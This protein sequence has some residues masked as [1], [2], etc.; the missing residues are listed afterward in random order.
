MLDEGAG[1]LHNNS[2]LR[3]GKSTERRLAQFRDVLNGLGPDFDELVA[4]WETGGFSDVTDADGI[5]CAVARSR[6]S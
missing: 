6:D 5:H 1:T 4:L 2:H 3:G